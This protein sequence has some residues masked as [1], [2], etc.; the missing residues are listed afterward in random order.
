LREKDFGATIVLQ[1]QFVENLTVNCAYPV[2]VHHMNEWQNVG[3]Q[4]IQ[5]AQLWSS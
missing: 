3:L 4:R 5:K 2:A 1:E